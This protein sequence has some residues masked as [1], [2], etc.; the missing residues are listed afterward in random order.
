M[1]SMM[2]NILVE[3]ICVWRSN[4]LCVGGTDGNKLICAIET[5][6]LCNRCVIL[7]FSKYI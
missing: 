4:G 7:G 3:M 6:N 1:I 5:I 2:M